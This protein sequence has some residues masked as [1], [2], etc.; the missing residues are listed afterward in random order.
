MLFLF[1]CAGIGGPYRRRALLKPP[2]HVRTC[3]NPMRGLLPLSLPSPIPYNPDLRHAVTCAVFVVVA[4]A[5]ARED[6][7]PS[8]AVDLGPSGCASLGTGVRGSHSTWVSSTA[9]SISI[10]MALVCTAPIPARSSAIRN[11]TPWLVTRARRS[12]PIS[13]NHSCCTC[14]LPHRML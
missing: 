9:S 3:E 4:C 11:P 12:S 1:F 7:Q 5:A 6:L 13:C 2:F 8:L 10:H 14:I